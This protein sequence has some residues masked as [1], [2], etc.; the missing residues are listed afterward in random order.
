M[1]VLLSLLH[2]LGCSDN[3]VS[4]Q[5]S[6]L[7]DQV[8][9]EYPP[10]IVIIGGGASGMSTAIRL[11][12]HGIQPIII[13]KEEELGG[14]GIH[15]GRFFAIE[16]TQQKEL[17]IED[18]VQQMLEE[19]STITGKEPDNTIEFFLR[20]SAATL[21]WI[22]SY[23][24][25]FSN[26]VID[27]GAGVLPRIHPLSPNVD[28]PLTIWANLL[29]PYSILGTSVLSIVQTDDTFSITTETDTIEATHVVIA[30]GGFA[31]NVELVSTF[32]P[33]IN[34]FDW[35]MEAWPGMTGD[36]FQWFDET[37]IAT[38]N[39]EH[40]GLY[41]HSVTDPI[42]GSPETMIIPALERSLIVSGEGIRVMDETKTQ[43]LQSGI[44]ML[45]HGPLFAIFDAD[46]WPGT[47]FQGTGYNYDPPRLLNSA[48]FEELG[49]IYTG[50]DI[51]DL[52]STL[53]IP[54]TNLSHTIDTYNQGFSSNSDE[55]GKDLTNITAVQRPP[56]IAVPL[57]LST[58]KSFGGAATSILTE[59]NVQNLYVVGE[60]AGF[61]GTPNVGWGFSG[62]ITACYHQ[63][64]Q[65]A[66][67]IYATL[68]E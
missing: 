33:E 2:L 37:N 22:E 49:L 48:E 41:A 36:A 67:A 47:H 29:F 51:Q 21:Q 11:L 26:P 3:S 53:E 65:A 46:A 1:F 58:G 39:T 24:V 27:A 13:E 14:A 20:N 68:S 43:S 28:H 64:F 63:G 45:H 35:H 16:S 50:S 38:Q 32:L 59:S 40:V 31:R 10:S 34:N 18:S 42:L 66:D 15:A 55:Y 9:D 4:D 54:H 6:L 19:W 8:T 57:V 12:E 17:N 56:F 23:G 5:P 52:A 61:L 44:E 7:D 62:S 25:Q 60:A 30:S